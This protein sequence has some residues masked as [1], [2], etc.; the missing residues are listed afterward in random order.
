VTL[1]KTRLLRT[2]GQE[3]TGPIAT[4]TAVS[5]IPEDTSSRGEEPRRTARING[6][7]VCVDNAVAILQCESNTLHPH[8]AHESAGELLD[9]VKQT[10]PPEIAAA[11]ALWSK[12][13]QLAADTRT[14]VAQQP[15][16]DL[17]PWAYH[18]FLAMFHKRGSQS[19][20]PP[21]KI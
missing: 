17:V 10:D 8:P 13:A 4:A 6:E 2:T 11:K 5:P 1:D 18:W 16:E 9:P 20:P 21:S 14:A 12:S 3:T 15:I 7:G 19:L